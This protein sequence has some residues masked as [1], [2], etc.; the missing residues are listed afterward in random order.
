MIT[1]RERAECKERLAS[2]ARIHEAAHAADCLC[3]VELH[4]DSGRVTTTGTHAAC[5]RLRKLLPGDLRRMAVL[6]ETHVG[7]TMRWTL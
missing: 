3:S 6:V 2:A 5:E 1:D 7:I 4:P